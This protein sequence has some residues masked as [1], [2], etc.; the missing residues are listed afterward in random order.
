MELREFIREWISFEKEVLIAMPSQIQHETPTDAAE[1]EAQGNQMASKKANFEPSPLDD[2]IPQA[3]LLH[4]MNTLT[5]LIF[6]D[7]KIGARIG[8][9]LQWQR[10]IGEVAGA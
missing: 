3:G 6:I 5:I 4:K 8:K 2:A 1:S 9:L 7:H 10:V